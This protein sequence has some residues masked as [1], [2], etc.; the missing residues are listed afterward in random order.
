MTTTATKTIIVCNTF[1]AMEAAHRL[2]DAGVT[3]DELN[4][5]VLAKHNIEG[6]KSWGWDLYYTLDGVREALRYCETKGE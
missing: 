4:G 6:D 2:R 1:A 3:S 5:D